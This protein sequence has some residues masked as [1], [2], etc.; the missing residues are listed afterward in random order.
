LEV[1]GEVVGAVVSRAWLRRLNRVA[2][3]SGVSGTREEANG[4]GE[5]TVWGA[6][7]GA[8]FTFSLSASFAAAAAAASF[9]TAFFFLIAFAFFCGDA[10][11]FS[12]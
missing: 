9:A 10:S 11:E 1:R 2:A 7:L 3:A 4:G 12:R 8:G 6:V 5:G